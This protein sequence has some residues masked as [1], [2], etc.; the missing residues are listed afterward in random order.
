MGNA[1][2]ENRNPLVS[3]IIPIRNGEKFIDKAIV[4]VINQTYKNL[5][6][7]CIDDRST[8]NSF[9]MLSKY[10]NKDNRMILI[11]EKIGDGYSAARNAGLRIFKGDFMFFLDIDDY[12]EIDYIENMLLEMDDDI[13]MIDNLFIHETIET[14]KR[15]VILYEPRNII[16]DNIAAKLGF[17]MAL[18][19]KHHFLQGLK[20]AAISIPHVVWNKFYKREA[21]KN[22][23][24]DTR[25]IHAEELSFLLKILEKKTR[26]K[27]VAN[28]GYIHTEEMKKNGKTGKYDDKIEKLTELALKSLELYIDSL[29]SINDDRKKIAL[30]NV[31]LSSTFI[32]STSKKYPAI[33]EKNKKLIEKINSLTNIPIRYRIIKNFQLLFP[34]FIPY[35][36]EKVRL[37]RRQG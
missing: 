21:V 7:I 16:I 26:V 14:K 22:I 34:K 25:F 5:E 2:K 37:K 30:Q 19:G 8:D 12:L 4:S 18:G 17:M 23:F 24:F 1:L 35:I 3:I 11:Q 27:L 32:F 10:K 6:I 33:Y 29:K 13:D 36:I 28:P 31:Y 20:G 9:I 15:K